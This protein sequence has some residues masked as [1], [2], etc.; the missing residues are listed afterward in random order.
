MR[1]FVFSIKIYTGYL[2]FAA[3]LMERM[4]FVIKAISHLAWSLILEGILLL[5]LGVLVYIYPTLIIVLVS[6]FLLVLGLTI[7]CIG[8]KVKKYS[9]IKVD[10]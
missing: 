3:K 6:V 7:F 9:K 2:M 4:E 5:A 10:F 8:L 1:H